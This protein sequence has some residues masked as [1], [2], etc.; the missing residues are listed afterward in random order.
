MLPPQ[1]QPSVSYARDFWIRK[2]EANSDRDDANEKTNAGAMT[3]VDGLYAM[4]DIAENT[5]IFKEDDM[6][7]CELHRT[8]EL[9]KANCKV[10]E[11]ED[12]MQAVVSS[13]FIK[14]GE[15]FCIPESSDE[16]GSDGDDNDEDEEGWFEDGEAE[17][18]E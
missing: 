3:N 16:E 15:F 17:E 1:T 4:D 10:V 13:K 2:D 14:A 8:S 9:E 11:L 5:V 12:G 7:D 18:D 6:P